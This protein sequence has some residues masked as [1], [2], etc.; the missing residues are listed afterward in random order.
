MVHACVGFLFDS[1]I[2]HG[3][4]GLKISRD[5]C[6][7]V[8]VALKDQRE[9]RRTDDGRLV[10]DGPIVRRKGDLYPVD[11]NVTGSKEGTSTNPKFALL[12]LWKHKLFPL[13]DKLTASGECKGARVIIQQDHAG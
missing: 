9:S 5:R 3:G 1:H 13:I 4:L 7:V 10:F 8:R 11:A 6:A 2:E 12:N